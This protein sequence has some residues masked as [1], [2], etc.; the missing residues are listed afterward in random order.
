MCQQALKCVLKFKPVL[1]FCLFYERFLSE[2]PKIIFC[3]GS[4]VCK[5]WAQRWHL[6]SPECTGLCQDFGKVS[7]M[8]EH[9][10][11]IAKPGLNPVSL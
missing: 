11:V 3:R 8:S 9:G 1:N 7:A 6:H 2:I 5:A 4:A 10:F